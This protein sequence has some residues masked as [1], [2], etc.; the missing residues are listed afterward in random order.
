M[1]FAKSND[2]LG[3]S[4]RGNPTESGLCTLCRADCSGKC[5]A[6]LSSLVGRKLLY[7]RSYGIVTA[8][9]N[10]TT[11]VGV[12]YNSLRIQG[13]A[14][15]AQGLNEQLTNSPDDCIFTNV[16]LETEFGNKVKTRA[17]I[18][19]MT[20]ALGSTFVAAKY[21]ESFAVGAAL[22]GIPVVIG[23]NVVGIDLESEIDPS[24]ERKGK[25]KKA[26]EL[27]RRINSYFRYYSGQGALIV[28]LN[29]EDTRNGVAEFVADKYGD[30]CIIELK[31]GQGAKDIGGEIQ[32][33]SL[34]YAL[35]LKKRGY[36]VDPD[37]ELP[38]VQ[39]AFE[40]RSVKSFARHSRLGATHL[41]SVEKVREDFMATVEYLRSLGFN[42]VTLKTGSYGMEELA[43]A[44][45]FATDA[46]LDLLTIDGSGGGT[47]MSPW[48]MMQSWGVPSINLHAKAYEYA[49]ILAA[50]GQK[51]VDL[52]FAG[53][54]ALE[55]SIFKG[56]ALGA[57]FV[58]MICMGRALMIPGFVGSNIEG[59]LFPERRGKLNGHWAELPKTV[60]RVG[61]N[62][63][64]IFACYHDI[65]K[66]VGKDEM[67]NIPYGAIA[68]YTMLDKL[69]G[70]LQQ[71]LAG[72]RKFSVTNIRRGD[73][74]SGNRE[75]ARET[76]IPHMCD[77]ND[78]SAKKI[79]NS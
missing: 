21:W 76:G 77:A 53:G 79:L 31:W 32:V 60:L 27:E 56:L 69:Y 49:N 55:D 58:K 47:G 26:P 4:N 24:T 52:S 42:R 13:Y 74:F 6:W 38:E 62:A 9:A 61:N 64:E 22:A 7:P 23:E 71:L 70:G 10:N 78:E 30:K 15:G 20:G 40:T 41:N 17:R 35:F 57:P 2:V 59:A 45:K 73:I 3:T 63:P 18:P 75:T 66:K 46:G 19:L 1:R 72:A 28:Q 34:D 33:R 12:S 14:Y 16:K 50:K 65:Q 39:Q 8:G 43:M 29:V 44:I 11:H 51:V 25:I 67:E 37:P 68:I 5:E 36:V 54:F 48:N